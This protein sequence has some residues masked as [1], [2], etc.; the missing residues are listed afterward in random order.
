MSQ[1]KKKPI[2]VKRGL[3]LVLMAAS[4]S[5]LAPM[6][7]VKASRG[8]KTSK[9]STER[10]RLCRQRQKMRTQELEQQVL[11]LQHEIS[12]LA[13]R[14][15]RVLYAPHTLTGSFVRAAHEYSNMFKNGLSYADPMDT[16]YN[17]VAKY[18]TQHSFVQSLF[19]PDVEVM[20]CDLQIA[21]GVTAFLKGWEVWA[22]WRAIKTCELQSIDV[23][24]SMD[25]LAVSL[26]VVRRVYL[27]ASIIMVLF[28]HVLSNRVLLAKIMGKHICYQSVENLFFNDQG[29]VAKYFIDID[30]FAT[31]YQ[32]VGNNEDVVELMKSCSSSSPS[33]SFVRE[34]NAEPST[35]PSTASNSERDSRLAV[36]FLLS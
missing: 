21:S 14:R 10:S 16:S 27:S 3:P 35:S 30:F 1:T 32:L 20:R 22:N 25:L 5:A 8:R 12:R 26:R 18:E 6:P 19:D 28:P 24:E 9:R 29:H 17:S 15:E 4:F 11:A 34:C 31:L 23:R 33:D 13:L 36:D 7:T 2:T